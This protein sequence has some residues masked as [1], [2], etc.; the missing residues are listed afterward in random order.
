MHL[1]YKN[2]YTVDIITH[3]SLGWFTCGAEGDK[4]LC[5]FA[6]ERQSVLGEGQFVQDV[7]DEVERGDGSHV[8]FQLIQHH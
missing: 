1:T 5:M 3:S 2:L 7:F 8:P 4:G 6:D